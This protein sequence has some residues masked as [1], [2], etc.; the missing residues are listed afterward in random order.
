M[1]GRANKRQIFAFYFIN[2]GTPWNGSAIL[3]SMI[4]S[5]L[6]PP[7]WEM[8]S[9]AR[10]IAVQPAIFVWK[11]VFLQKVLLAE[12]TCWADGLFPPCP[13]LILPGVW[14]SGT[15]VMSLTLQGSLSII[16]LLCAVFIFCLCR[17]K[18]T[19]SFTWL[20]VQEKATKGAELLLS[21]LHRPTVK[22][23]HPKWNC[24]SPGE[25]AYP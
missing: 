18:A 14:C 4:H 7:K 5:D 6:Q 2:S 22:P 17:A 20:I 12:D 15:W 3:F 25:H 13:E 9:I 24:W 8:T 11:S 16:L 23:F 10:L 21:G 19:L 1:E